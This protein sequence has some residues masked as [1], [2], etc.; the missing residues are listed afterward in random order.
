MS[1]N[2][3]VQVETWNYILCMFPALADPPKPLAVVFPQTHHQELPISHL[4]ISSIFSP[5]KC[6]GFDAFKDKA[7]EEAQASAAQ[8]N[9][10]PDG[11]TSPSRTPTPR[12][13]VK[14]TLPANRVNSINPRSFNWSRRDK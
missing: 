12:A 8:K 3:A 1:G 5:G 11:Q 2:T 10:Y 4:P 6:F 7:G 14:P 13:G 9:R